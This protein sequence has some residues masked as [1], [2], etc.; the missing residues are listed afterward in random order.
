MCSQAFLV[1]V[2]YV[3]W[4]KLTDDRK[5]DYEKLMRSLDHGRPFAERHAPT[6]EDFERF[7]NVFQRLAEAIDARGSKNGHF[8]GGDITFADLAVGAF[9]QFLRHVLSPGRFKRLLELNGDRWKKL[10]D[11]LAEFTDVDEGEKYQPKDD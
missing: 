5:P 1:A 4:A 11:E 7:D 2:T 9:L 8:Y 3:T 10:V 6:D